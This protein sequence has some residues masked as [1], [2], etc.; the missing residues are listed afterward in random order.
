MKSFASIRSIQLL[1]LMLLILSLP[2]FAQTSLW[3]VSKGGKHLYLGGTIHVLGHEDYP[4]PEEF[5]QA[6]SHSDKIVFE[7][8][9]AQAREPAFAKK[10]MAQM[11]YTP[12]KSLKNVLDDSTYQRLADYFSDKVSMDQIDAMKPG[13]VVIMMAAIEYQSMGMVIIG[14]DEHFWNLAQQTGKKIDTLET[15]DEQLSF[16]V[17]MGLGNENELILN[18][19]NDLKQTKSMINLLRTS[20][21][22]GNDAE[23][24]KIILQ[25]MIDNYPELYQT[26]LVKR[27]LNWLPHLETMF[28]DESVALILVGALHLV[29]EDGLLQLLRNKGYEVTYFK[30]K[31]NR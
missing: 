5:E 1:I 7:T 18:T 17:N 20:W 26:I 31:D 23:M 4:L 2:V 28:K 29:G 30:E 12:G 21:R 13:M 16:L 6:F 10:L 24:K 9:I 3:Q 19:L 25:D 15:M 27:N 14:V 11:L 8:D 22:T